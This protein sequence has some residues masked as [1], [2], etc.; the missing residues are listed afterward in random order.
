MK[1]IVENHMVSYQKIK[2]KKSLNDF[3]NLLTSI[4]A[5]MYMYRCIDGSKQGMN[6][7]L[8]ISS[9][10]RTKICIKSILKNPNL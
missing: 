1:R 8:N 4:S 3:K 2:P 7:K 10:N 5:Y 9:F 6:R